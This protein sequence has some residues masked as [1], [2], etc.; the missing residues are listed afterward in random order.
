M[1]LPFRWPLAA[2]LLAACL[3]V[4]AVGGFA[5]SLPA[6]SHRLHPVALLGAHGMAHAF[7]FNLLVFI[8]PGVLAAAMA[9]GL[10]RGLADT[11]PWRARIGLQL[12]LLSG[13]AFAMQGLLPLDPLDMDGADSRLHAAA[14][15]LWLLAFVPGALLS[16]SVREPG[17]AGM[18]GARV[19]GIA[20]AVLV[21]TLALAG[22]LAMPAAIAQRLAFA[23]WFAW[24]VL[25]AAKVRTLL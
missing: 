4:G 8:V 7:A 25:A 20:I 22:A 23:L 1:K 12:V 19:V 18:Q 3:W 6:Y 21:P 15:M 24:L 9:A 14:W 5:A 16:D 11:A 17:R 13:L 2:A 10:R